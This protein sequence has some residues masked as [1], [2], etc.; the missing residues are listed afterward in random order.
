MA[1]KVSRDRGYRSDTIAISRDMGPLREGPGTIFNCVL[2]WLRQC[3]L[4]QPFIRCPP[5][6]WLLL[7]LPQVPHR[8][9]YQCRRQSR[10]DTPAMTMTQRTEVKGMRA[11]SNLQ[12]F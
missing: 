7:R 4:S 9:S 3:C 1:E 10:D 12:E 6:R 11:D 5:V 2:L 8:A